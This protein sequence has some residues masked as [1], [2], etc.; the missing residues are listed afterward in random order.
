MSVVHIK[1]DAEFNTLKNSSGTFGAPA[2]VI[3]DFSAEVG[4][5][6]EDAVPGLL[7]HA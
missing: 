5:L 7:P 2:A 1:S 4:G 3:V 6:A